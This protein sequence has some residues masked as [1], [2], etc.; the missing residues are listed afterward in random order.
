VV[1]DVN[2][3][4]ATAQSGRGSDP[5]GKL[6]GTAGHARDPAWIVVQWALLADRLWLQPLIFGIGAVITALAA[7]A[8]S[9]RAR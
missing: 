9:R 1:C 6:P 3:V 7:R 2:V 4:R 5:R 8:L